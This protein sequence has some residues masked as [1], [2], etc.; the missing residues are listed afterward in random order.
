[1]GLLPSDNA[2]PEGLAKIESLP[3]AINRAGAENEVVRGEDEILALFLNRH[4]AYLRQKEME[5]KRWRCEIQEI[6]Q[7]RREIEMLVLREV[8]GRS[9]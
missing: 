1:V 4:E 2:G 8:L 9:G 5:I 3:A 6:R 7:S